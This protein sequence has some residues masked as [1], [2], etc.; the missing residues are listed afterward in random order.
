M[1]AKANQNEGSGQVVR[2]LDKALSVLLKLSQA[3]RDI[4]LATLAAQTD[5]P[6][7]TLVR[8][9]H[10]MRLHNVVQQDLQT[11]RYRLGWGLINLGKAA[12]RQF[13]LE[14]I[15][16][17]Y[18]EQLKKETGETA[19][20]AILEGTRAVYLAQVPADSI[21]RGVPPIG[22]E[23]Q[24]HCTAVGK[25]LLTSYPEELFEQRVV[26]HGLPRLTENTIVNSEQLR[27]EIK[28]VA[29]QG[30]AV[31]NEEAECGG[32]CI[33]SPIIGSDGSVIAA[34]SI[35]GPISRIREDR[36]GEYAEIVKRIA[37]RVT[38][39]LRALSPAGKGSR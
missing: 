30:F 38:E 18:L 5:L 31:D 8:L 3:E 32:R 11:R 24:L 25:V 21:I 26:E 4:D 23:L 13:D 16:L 27:K 36:I 39:A 2:A 17:P 14:K 12:E 22:S 37:Q 10:T 35:T 19:S 1:T 28:V 7:S 34:I 33:A 29:S 6:K 9:L 20:F 15:V